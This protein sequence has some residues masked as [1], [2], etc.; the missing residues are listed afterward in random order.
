MTAAP[1]RTFRPQ[2]V[3]PVAPIDI[4]SPGGGTDFLLGPVL[5][6]NGTLTGFGLMSTTTGGDQGR[7]SALTLRPRRPSRRPRR[8]RRPRTVTVQID[9]ALT[10]SEGGEQIVVAMRPARGGSSREQ[11][12]TAASNGRFTT[13]WRIRGR[14]LFVAR[15]AGDDDRR[16]AG[17][18]VISV[19]PR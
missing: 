14:T 5:A 11:T 17:S 3:Q 7:V 9:G 1:P 16:G 12:V 2:V 8:T 19:T 15:F 4:A 13:S 6:S 10:P 18:L